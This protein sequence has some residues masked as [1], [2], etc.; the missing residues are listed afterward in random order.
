MKKTYVTPEVEYINFYS[1]EF[2]TA[3]ASVTYGEQE[4]VEDTDS[5]FWG[6]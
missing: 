2:I 5:G 3:E 4:G 1:E 6:N